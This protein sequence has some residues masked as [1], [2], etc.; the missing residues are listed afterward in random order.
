MFM[1][2][3]LQC[4][5]DTLSK[6]SDISPLWANLFLSFSDS[7][8][9]SLDFQS[10]T[11]VFFSS[12]YQMVWRWPDITLSKSVFT[13]DVPKSIGLLSWWLILKMAIQINFRSIWRNNSNTTV[14]KQIYGH[15]FCLFI[16]FHMILSLDRSSYICSF[17][18]TLSIEVHKYTAPEHNF[19]H[20][21]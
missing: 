14:S 1:K 5:K 9:F 6:L 17:V 12:V 8:V 3:I 21:M 4:W 7:Y 10:L 11:T 20:V 19:F 18:H 16:F 13:H 15:I 2:E